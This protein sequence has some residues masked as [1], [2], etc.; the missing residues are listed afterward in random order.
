LASNTSFSVVFHSECC[1]AENPIR[2][3]IVSSGECQCRTVD[4]SLIR[5]EDDEDCV[6]SCY[7]TAP[8]VLA[9]P[10]ASHP[11]IQDAPLQAVPVNYTVPSSDRAHEHTSTSVPPTPDPT[12]LEAR[13][14]SS[15]PRLR[16]LVST[17]RPSSIATTRNPPLRRRATFPGRLETVVDTEDEA[18]PDT[19]QSVVVAPPE[20]DVIPK[21]HMIPPR[22]NTAPRAGTSNTGHIRWVI[23]RE[24]PTRDPSLGEI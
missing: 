8:S 7:E 12:I 21:T 1:I 9:T 6:T 17:T 11:R 23:P 13:I 14:P 24:H 16:D 22:P 20:T 15:E 5:V 2:A 19:R 18:P 4:I 10:V 3:R